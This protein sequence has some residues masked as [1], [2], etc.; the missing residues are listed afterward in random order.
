MEGYLQKWVNPFHRWQK[1]YFILNNDILTYC[2]EKG[3]KAKGQIHLKVAGIS[4][5]LNDPLRIV[6]YTGINH[7]ILKANDSKECH[8][9]VTSLK[10]A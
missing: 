6:I 8:D 9:W 4:W 2:D 10:K 5:N 7:L 1:R 3:G